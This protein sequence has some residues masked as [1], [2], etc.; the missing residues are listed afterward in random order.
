VIDSVDFGAIVPLQREGNW[1][2]TGAILAASAQRLERAG[3]TVLGIGANTMHVNFDRRFKTPSPFPSW[4][5]ASR[6]RRNRS[7]VV[8]TRSRCSARNT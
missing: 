3:A 7:E 2:A 8:T 1:D 6:S 4:T 5:C